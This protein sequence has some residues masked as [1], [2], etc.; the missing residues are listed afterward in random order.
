MALNVAPQTFLTIEPFLAV[1]TVICGNHFL[2]I[3]CSGFKD[4]LSDGENSEPEPS[5][6]LQ[7]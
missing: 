7:F 5:R 6:N 1:F 3:H 2:A 4:K